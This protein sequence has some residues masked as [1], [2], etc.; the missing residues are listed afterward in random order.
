MPFVVLKAA[1]GLDQGN[2]LTAM[3]GAGFEVREYDPKRPLAEQVADVDVLLT[4]DVPVTAA[5][6]DAA[7]RL[8]LLQRY[9]QHFSGADL[10]HAFAR[11]IHVAR[12]LPEATGSDRQVAEHAMFL[13]LA[14]AKQ[15]GLARAAIAERRVGWPKT[16]ALVDKTLGMVGVGKT[17][18]Q[19]AK[20][21]RGFGMK[22]IGVKRTADAGL[23]A[24]LGMEWI[25]GM[26]AYDELLGQADVVSIHLPLEPGTVGFFGGDAFAAMKTG[27]IL[28][29]IARGPIVDRDALLAALTSG[30]LAGAGLDVLWQEPIDP[31]DPLLALPNVVAT[32]HIAAQS[33]ETQRVLAALVAENIRRVARGE[34]P[35]FAVEPEAARA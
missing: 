8:K 7:P 6:I 34:A 13:L 11:R 1:L 23:A 27:A 3:L 20:L 2:L 9:G 25:R 18:E 29:N 24:R 5:V 12:I 15:Y 4:R 19:L 22:V 31:L 35:R 33:H 10:A 28:I 17:G 16:L 30:R 14:V 21:A 32:P 26:A